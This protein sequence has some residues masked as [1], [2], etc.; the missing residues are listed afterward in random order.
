MLAQHKLLK[1]HLRAEVMRMQEGRLLPEDAEGVSATRE[2][3]AGLERH[4]RQ[5]SE[6]QQREMEKVAVRS[7][8]SRGRR[9]T[10][11]PNG[12]SGC[13]AKRVAGVGAS[14]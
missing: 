12:E 14:F 6:H 1:D 2:A 9:C 10:S 11:N 5:L 3:I 4:L 7:T 13:G 8:S